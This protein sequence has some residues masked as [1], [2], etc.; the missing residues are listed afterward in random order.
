MPPSQPRTV[1]LSDFQP[2]DVSTTLDPDSHKALQ[3]LL[4]G[5]RGICESAVCVRRN[6]DNRDN[7]WTVIPPSRYDPNAARQ[8][9]LLTI[10][11][12]ERLNYDIRD[13]S[14]DGSPHQEGKM[15]AYEPGNL[16]RYLARVREVIRRLAP[17]DE[18]FASRSLPDINGNLSPVREV[19]TSTS[20]RLVPMSVGDSDECS[21]E[22]QQNDY[23]LGS[24]SGELEGTYFCHSTLNAE[25]GTPVLFQYRSRVIAFARLQRSEE[26]PKP[27][28]H[29]YRKSMVFDPASIRVFAPVSAEQMREIWPG[30]FKKFTH[31]KPV[32]NAQGLERFWALVQ[33]TVR[34]PEFVEKT[35][36]EAPGGW[37]GSTK[38]Y[39]KGGSD[40]VEVSADHNKMQTKLRD[41]LAKEYGAPNV[42][43]EKD[44]VDI[45]VTTADERILFEIKPD[46][47]PLSVIRQ[48][49]GQLLEYAY[50][51]PDTNTDRKLRLVIVGRTRLSAKE[52][53][54]L[55]RL[56]ETFHLPLSYRVVS[57]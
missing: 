37:I 13:Q 57:I 35:R 41:E 19:V 30:D 45:S 20:V 5:M 22:E 9:N 43:T 12:N 53:A 48:A 32:L 51:N 25:T 15:R 33:P 11:G 44:H 21:I 34:A 6:G 4:V 39:T 26:L 1:P 47:S 18:N 28:K 42:V 46:P 55:Q 7:R 52:S 56:K 54:Y 40:P 10:G 49:L 8:H 27:N 23:F 24:L 16:D 36:K 31:A 14:P 17:E 29:G 50:L 2:K 38:T 3:R